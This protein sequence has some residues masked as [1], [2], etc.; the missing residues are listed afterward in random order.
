MRTASVGADLRVR[1]EG[2][3]EVLEAAVPLLEAAAKS[4]ANRFPTADDVRTLEKAKAAWPE[5]EEALAR[6]RRAQG[7]EALV[8]SID[9]PLKKI[10]AVEKIVVPR[11]MLYPA[12][13]ET[14]FD[15][16]AEPEGNDVV[17][18]VSTALLVVALFVTRSLM[19]LVPIALALLMWR[20]HWKT[21]RRPRRWAVLPDR[22]HFE[23]RDYATSRLNAEAVS[24]NSVV[25]VVNGDR[26]QLWS[27]HPPALVALI[28]LLGNSWLQNLDSRPAPHTIEGDT[29]KVAEGELTFT[30]GALEEL[31][32]QMQVESEGLDVQTLLFVLAHVPGPRWKELGPHL[33][34]MGAIWDR[35]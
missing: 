14:K 35:K 7:A 5:I 3:V 24:E 6:A 19:V 12:P 27:A 4:V 31:R 15:Q 13:S 18:A 8:A 17:F 22:F 16:A 21:A 11:G 28:Q 20:S 33:D 2:G 1:M 25:V 10:G 30:I 34:S 26:R 29:L 32:K 23:G 9:A